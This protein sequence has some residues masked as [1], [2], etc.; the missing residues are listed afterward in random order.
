V[1][2]YTL[3]SEDMATL[4]GDIENPTGVSDVYIIGQNKD[5][6]SY[7][8]FSKTEY[9][10]L[11]L[12]DIENIPYVYNVA[13]PCDTGQKLTKELV[14]D[15]WNKMR[16]DNYPPIEEYVD[17]LVKND[18]IQIQKYIDDCNAVKEMFPK[19]IV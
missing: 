11:V 4:F 1:K 14:N 7:V 10:E 16:K 12:L 19:I 17:G 5:A 8:V 9:P 15:V 18:T 3:S 2:L 6:S 13:Y